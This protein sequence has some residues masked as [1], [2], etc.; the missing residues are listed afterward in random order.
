MTFFVGVIVIALMSR[1]IYITL[2]YDFNGWKLGRI[3]SG[4]IQNKTLVT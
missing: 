1:W 3:G 4:K 2:D